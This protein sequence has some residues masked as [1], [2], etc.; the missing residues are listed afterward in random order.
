M[1]VFICVKLTLFAALVAARYASLDGLT[2]MLSR[3]L[4]KFKERR[5]SKNHDS[6]GVSA[7]KAGLDDSEIDEVDEEGDVASTVA[8][9]ENYA[10]TYAAEA[11]AYGPAY[12]IVKTKSFSMVP[13]TPD[14][15]ALCLSYLDHPFYVFR[16]KDTNEVN[17]L[18]KRSGGGLGLIEPA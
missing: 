17:V 13:I 16:N 3:K 1:F 15:A 9:G 14:E 11:V 10:E 8:D 18:Y 2:D 6:H 5:R 7:I 4:R 12:E